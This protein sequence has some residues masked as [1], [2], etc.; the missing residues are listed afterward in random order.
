M[1]AGGGTGGHLFPALALAEAFQ[2]RDRGN[3]I[4]FVAGRRGLEERILSQAGF[5]LKTIEVTGLKG[6]S[7]RAKGKGLLAIPRSLVQSWK[8]IRGFRPDVV[9]GMGGYASGPVVLTAWGLGVKTAIHEQN[10]YPGLSNRILGRFVKRAFLSFPS[11]ARFFPPAKRMITGNPVRK[12]IGGDKGSA[13]RVEDSPFTLLIFGG[14]QGAHRLNRAM[15]EGLKNLEELRGRMRII[16]Q[17]GDR[18]WQEVQ[19]AYRQE[20]FEAE[21][22][23]F[24]QEMDRAYAAADLV[25]CRAGATTLFE[26]MAAG[27]P[28]ILVPYPHA[29]NDHQRLNA[30]ALV[31]AGAALMVADG[32][33]NG[34]SLT[35]LV[36]QLAKDPRRRSRMAAR[37][38]ALAQPEAAERIVNACYTM[39]GH[40]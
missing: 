37:A 32:N 40:E 18:D 14:S 6:R 26:L 25:L 33:L 12:S 3:T 38:A 1:I 39:V 29:A 24:I 11:S 8:A 7:A 9:L 22:H 23:P 2:A 36:R 34:R 15:I 17:T 35:D 20:T 19:S 10:A 27:K 28:A 5:G 30:Q 16:H 21:V 4:L 13:S 31:D